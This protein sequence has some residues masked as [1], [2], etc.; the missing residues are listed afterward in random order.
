MP[1]FFISLFI[2][3]LLAVAVF[4]V[5]RLQASVDEIKENEYPQH[6]KTMS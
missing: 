4:G 2:V 3:V 6:H 5:Y 1:K